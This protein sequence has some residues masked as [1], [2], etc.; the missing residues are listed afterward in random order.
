MDRYHIPREWT[1][2]ASTLSPRRRGAEV[3]QSSVRAA[4][5]TTP[6]STALWMAKKK[7]GP[8]ASKKIQ[9]KLLQHVAGVGQAGDV[10]LVTPPFFHNKLRPTRSAQLISDDQVAAEQS[11]AAEAAEQ[12]AAQALT[13]QTKW[14][15]SPPLVVRRKAGPDGHLFGGVGAKAILDQLKESCS[16]GEEAEFLSRK[17]VK[18][19]ALLDSEGKKLR[20]DIKQ[21]GS[22]AASLVLTQ[23]ISVKVEIEVQADA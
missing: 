1:G 14:Q 4:A 3:C 16:S 9:V 2:V 8:A 7:P 19:T 21:T 12:T 5:Q 17:G 10:V 11:Q 13:L 18:L 6:V 23:D 22:F 20:G 15:S